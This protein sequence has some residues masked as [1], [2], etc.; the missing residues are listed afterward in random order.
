MR[1]YRGKKRTAMGFLILV[2]I[3]IFTGMLAREIFLSRQDFRGVQ[4]GNS[5]TVAEKIRTGLKHRAYK[6]HIS[7]RAHTN[8][9]ERIKALVDDLLEKALYESEDP[10]GG[11]YIRYQL[12]GYR[13]NYDVEKTLLGYNYRMELIP[14]CYSSAKEEK[15][16]DREV[17]KIMEEMSARDLPEEERVRV[18]HDYVVQNLSYDSVHKS[19]I[20]H[21]RKTTA[22]HALKYHQAVCQGYAVLCYRLLKELGIHCRIVTGLFIPDEDTEEAAERHAWLMVTVN[23]KDLYMDPTLDDV[24]SSYDWY[25]KSAEDFDKDHIREIKGTQ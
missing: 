21:H 22:Y 18:V 13:M 24:N 19:N 4:I 6:L 14:T 12:G 11:D 15:Y 7:F 2:L 25:L 16:V 9:E 1:Q 17:E 8:D 20:N 23:G 3:C 5:E 10:T